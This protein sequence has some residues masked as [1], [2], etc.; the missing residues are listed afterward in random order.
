VA[1]VADF[2]DE[3]NALVAQAPPRRRTPSDQ[4]KNGNGKFVRDI[5][6]VERDAIAA[7]LYRRG[8]NYQQIAEK[9]G[10][11]DRSNARMAVKRAFGEAI[12]ESAADLLEWFAAQYAE[13]QAEITAYFTQTHYVVTPSGKVAVGPD[14]KP[15]IDHEAKLKGVDRWLKSLNDQARLLGLNAPTGAVLQVSGGGNLDA[16]IAGLFAAFTAGGDPGNKTL[17]G[18]VVGKDGGTSEQ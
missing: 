2:D 15:L 17:I 9:L 7:K 11:G 6:S 18:E 5:E 13:I 16:E 8:L 4:P 1:D 14:G 12:K 3:I 10:L